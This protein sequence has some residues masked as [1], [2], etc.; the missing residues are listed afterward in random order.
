MKKILSCLLIFMV[1]SSYRNGDLNRDGKV[2]TTDLVIMRQMVAGLKMPSYLADLNHDCKVDEK[3]LY[4]I[5]HKLA[6]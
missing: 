5:R 6:N 1:F 4:I 3:D 2:S